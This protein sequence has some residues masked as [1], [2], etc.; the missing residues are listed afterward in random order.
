MG[1]AIAG[2]ADPAA[3]PTIAEEVNHQ[4]ARA[5]CATLGLA[6]YDNRHREMARLRDPGVSD[7]KIARRLD[8][9]RAAIHNAL[10]PRADW[11]A[12]REAW[13][14]EHSEGVQPT[15]S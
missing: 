15:G 9:A 4:L 14:A 5:A 2:W 3:R 12:T 8:C 6:R 1:W 11:E 13:W 7:N 10:G